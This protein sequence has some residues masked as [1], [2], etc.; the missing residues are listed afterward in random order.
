LV[1]LKDEWNDYNK[2]KHWN[3]YYNY[4]INGVI[5]PNFDSFSG[6]ILDLKEKKEYGLKYFYDIIEK[7]LSPGIAI[8]YVPSHDPSNVNSGIRILA[9]RLAANKGRIDATSC[10]ERHTFVAKKAHGGDRR[11]EVDL[12]SIHVKNKELLRNRN[13]L[14]LDDVTTSGN[15][16]MACR[17]LLSLNSN[18]LKIQCFA[19]GKTEG[20]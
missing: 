11:I 1:F 20:Y 4:R 9:Q 3:T 16:L 7:H 12:R 8:A 13:V 18:A 10:L 2:V 5:N 19:F 6:L 17:Q 15:S 14:L